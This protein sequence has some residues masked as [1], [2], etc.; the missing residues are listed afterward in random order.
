LHWKILYIQSNN[1]KFGIMLLKKLLN[2]R[3]VLTSNA[4]LDGFVVDLIF[5]M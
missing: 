5:Q 2:L 3:A 1:K 4:K